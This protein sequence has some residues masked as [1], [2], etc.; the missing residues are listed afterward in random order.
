[1]EFVAK[2]FDQLTASE[3]YEILRSRSEVF[4][5]EQGIVC[6]DMDGIDRRALHCFLWENGRV[7][8]Y[9]RA[10]YSQEHPHTV[11][12]GRV[13]TLKHGMGHGRLLMERSLKELYRSM[14]FDE[15]KLHSQ[16]HASAFYQKFGFRISSEEF[17]EEGIP[18]VEMILDHQKNIY[19]Q[20][21]I[22]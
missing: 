18:H 9:L 15:L 8:A 12:L 10:F 11:K 14:P 16:T 13:L 17:D 2:F 5:L 7:I 21:S 6:Q 20:E 22:L 1:M 19:F 4:L 3:L